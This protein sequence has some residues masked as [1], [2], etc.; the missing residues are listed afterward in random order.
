MRGIPRGTVLLSDRAFSPTLPAHYFFVR[1]RRVRFFLVFSGFTDGFA[2][3]AA[4]KAPLAQATIAS[5]SSNSSGGASYYD[6]ETG[7]LLPS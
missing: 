1:L 4:A 7:L 6:I 5:P 3:S 2:R